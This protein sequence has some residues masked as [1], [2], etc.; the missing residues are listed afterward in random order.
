LE[1]TDE[2]GNKTYTFRVQHPN[3]TAS[4]FYNMTMQEFIDGSSMVKLFEYQMTPDF[5]LKYN[6]NEKEIKDFEGDYSYKLLAYTPKVIDPNGSSGG[7]GEGGGGG[8]SGD[9]TSPGGGSGS[10]GGSGNNSNPCYK[11]IGTIGSG[12]GGGSGVGNAPGG[13]D[14]GSSGGNGGGSGSGSGGSG[15][16][17]GGGITC[18]T[19]IV[20]MQKVSSSGVCYDPYDVTITECFTTANRTANRTGGPCAQSNIGIGLLSPEVVKATFIRNLMLHS[21]TLHNQFY[22]LPESFK[23]QIYNLAIAD[24]NGAINFIISLNQNNQLTW[25]SQ[26]SIAQQSN[27]ISY[28][29]S[30]E[31]SQYS[32]FF[33]FQAM[34][35]MMTY[36]NLHLDLEASSKSPF[37]IDRYAIN[38]ATPE[39]EKFNAIYNKLAEVPEFKAL[40]TAIFGG[41]EPL[42]NVKF[43]IADIPNNN[44][45]FVA[46]ETEKIDNDNFIIRINS[47][48]MTDAGT[49]PMNNIEIAKTILHECIHA[50]LHVVAQNTGATINNM[51]VSQALNAIYPVGTPQHNFMIQNMLPTMEVI[52][53]KLLNDLTTK[54]QRNNCE[55]Y[56]EPQPW[57]WTKYIYFLC[58]NG[59]QGTTEFNSLLEPVY[60]SNNLMTSGNSEGLLY[61]NYIATGRLFLMN[62]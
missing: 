50:Y 41:N 24:M 51:N 43:E 15:G 30:A 44:G 10:G 58:L 9:D 20:H 40:F 7:D 4:K 27:I 46:G 52:L 3:G 60:D 57:I 49:Q 19:I 59:L 29:G 37:N 18:I 42:K 17:S 62:P 22:Y 33:A 28:L 26:Q 16:G 55:Q 53:N 48:I 14:G 25:L 39:G 21:L 31:F 34:N 11:G 38:N 32:Y 61:I 23:T 8:G 56:G 5:A 35:Q 54:E 6:N 36:P 12:G 1:V 47:Q 13:G 2:K 45:E